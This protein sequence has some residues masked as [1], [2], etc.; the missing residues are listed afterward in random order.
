ME[1]RKPFLIRTTKPRPIADIYSQNPRLEGR[2]NVVRI[3]GTRNDVGKQYAP[4]H[5]GI[6]ESEQANNLIE[7]GAYI[8]KR[9]AQL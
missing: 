2:A 8:G 9:I 1:S 6:A 3:G 5:I 4:L 7:Q